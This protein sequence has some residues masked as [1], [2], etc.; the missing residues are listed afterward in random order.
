MPRKY[1]FCYA[2][3]T[4]E[5]TSSSLYSIKKVLHLFRVKVFAL[6]LIDSTFS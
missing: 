2:R 3:N 4:Q 5:Q 1:R 6:I